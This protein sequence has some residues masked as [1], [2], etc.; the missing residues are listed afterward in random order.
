M[1]LPIL[2]A[3][4][5]PSPVNFIMATD[6]E[7]DDFLL[8]DEKRESNSVTVREADGMAAVEFAPQGVKRKMRLERV[9]LQVGNHAGEAW[10]EVG[11][12]FEEFA[13]LA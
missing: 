6:I 5:F 3:G 9:V 2:V 8:C 11:M 7:E 12:F 1:K 13:G 10:L 4:A